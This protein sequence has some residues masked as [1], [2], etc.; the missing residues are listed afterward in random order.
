MAI[1]GATQDVLSVR[2]INNFIN[3][4]LSR[5]DFKRPNIIRGEGISGIKEHLKDKVLPALKQADFTIEDFS[6]IPKNGDTKALY[7]ALDTLDSSGSND[8]VYHITLLCMFKEITKANSHFSECKVGEGLQS[9]ALKKIK[10]F[11]DNFKYVAPKAGEHLEQKIKNPE[12]FNR[13]A[14]EFLVGGISLLLEKKRPDLAE[15][16]HNTLYIGS[17]ITKNVSGMEFVEASKKTARMLV[18]SGLLV[19][20][21]LNGKIVPKGAKHEIFLAEEILSTCLR[22][23]IFAVPFSSTLK[24]YSSIEPVRKRDFLKPF[25]KNKKNKK[26][27]VASINQIFEFAPDQRDVRHVSQKNNFSLPL[28]SGGKLPPASSYPPYRQLPSPLRERNSG[29]STIGF[30]DDDAERVIDSE[31]RHL[32]FSRSVE[33][34]PLEG[35]GLKKRKKTRKKN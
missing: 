18:H 33:V 14:H 12:E 13:K 9:Q 6:K 5:V 22:S 20:L 8:D 7:C 4:C 15:I 17:L 28:F 16:L 19:P 32:V 27:E 25:E 10:Y 23:K 2:Q 26:K 3:L 24:Y 11:K 35:G 21:G 1:S 30:F 31:P 29:T 34:S